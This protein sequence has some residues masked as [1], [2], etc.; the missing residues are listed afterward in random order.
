MKRLVVGAIMGVGL[1][2]MSATASAQA[3]ESSDQI[4]AN[5]CAEACF[6]TVIEKGKLNDKGLKHGKWVGRYKKSNDLASEGV[7]FNGKR[8]GIWK[9]YRLKRYAGKSDGLALEGV[10][11]NDV[12]VK[13]WTSWSNGQRSATRKYTNA[14]KK[15]LSTWYHKGVKRRLFNEKLATVDGRERWIMDGPYS[16]FYKGKLSEK[17]QYLNGKKH[18]NWTNY[19]ASSGK[20]TSKAQFRNGVYSGTLNRFYSDGTR[21]CE[22]RFASKGGKE[23]CW[24]KNGKKRSS[25]PYIAHDKGL[26]GYA[27]H[28]E[29]NYWSATGKLI[30]K[31]KYEKGE[32][33]G[34][35]TRWYDNGKVR[36]QVR[37]VLMKSKY[38]KR[39]R[40]ERDGLWKAYHENGQLK[41]QGEYKAG[42]KIGT[43]RYWDNKGAKDKLEVYDGKSYKPK[44]SEK[45]R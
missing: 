11:K 9:F 38:S 13:T 32:R 31:G 39:L 42:N 25:V 4:K 45:W 29:Y 6:G 12:K 22:T 24:H 28:G 21:S 35:W 30:E 18:G 7:Y 17:G 3:V 15:R 34:L 41:A 19:S 40:G 10:Y 23:K 5:W 36:S 2:G 20:V 37:Y 26:Y 33:V 44:S 43:W 27:R 8:T 1:L 14:G 16:S